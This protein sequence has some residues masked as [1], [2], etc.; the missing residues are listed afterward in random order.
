[1]NSRTSNESTKRKKPPFSKLAWWLAGIYLGWSLFVYFSTLGG[2]GHDWWPIW[3]FPL[4]LPW[5]AVHQFMIDPILTHWIIPNPRSAPASA[6]IEL[7]HIAGAYYIV[8]GTIWYWIIGKTISRRIATRRR[9]NEANE[10]AAK[11]RKEH[12]DEND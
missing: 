5:S 1:V 3:L 10:M 9:L 2:V 8:I 11:E 6:W 12:K 4:I 7:D